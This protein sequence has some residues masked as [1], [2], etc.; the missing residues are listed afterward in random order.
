MPPSRNAVR[1]QAIRRTPEQIDLLQ[2][3]TSLLRSRPHPLFTVPPPSTSSAPAA[4]PHALHL[5]FTCTIRLPLPSPF[6]SP[7]CTLPF[8]T[9]TPPPPPHTHTATPTRSY[10][11]SSAP[12][13]LPRGTRT[14]CLAQ[15]LQRARH[16]V[17]LQ[18]IYCYAGTST[19]TAFRRACSASSAGAA[20]TPKRHTRPPVQQLATG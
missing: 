9:P 8:L 16:L 7:P 5:Y 12:L 11:P 6:L 14:S 15:I 20:G 13:S 3:R 19:S 17:Q 1:L 4:S 10:T 2:Q 18:S